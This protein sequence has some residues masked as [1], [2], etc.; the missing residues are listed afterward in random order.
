MKNTAL[1]NV[2]LIAIDDAN[3]GI[4]ISDARLPD[5]PLIFVN[6]GFC[7]MTGYNADEVMGKNCRFL[8]GKEINQESVRRVKKSI[9]NKDSI[10]EEIINFKK[11]GT[12]FW[13]RLSITPIFDDSGILSHFI[14]VQEDITAKKEKE[15]LQ[16]KMDDQILVNK[17]TLIAEEKQKKEIGVEL[18]DNVN[19]ILAALKLYLAMALRDEFVRTEMLEKS[20]EMLNMAMDEI[21]KLSKSLVGP[22]I[23]QETLEQAV[24]ELINYTQIGVSFIIKLV[25]DEDIEQNLSQSMKLTLYRIIQEQLNNIG[26]YANPHIVKIEFTK[27]DDMIHLSVKDDGIGFNNN[28]TRH[29][30]GLKNMKHR[31]EMENGH[32]TILTS[33]GSGCEIKVDL[34]YE[35]IR[36]PF[37]LEEMYI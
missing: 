3:E 6:K 18:H 37:V 36:S 22:N 16:H 30:I 26:K 17:T 19:Q 12:I 34:P 29:G 8:Q 20:E 31:S 33:L 10:I 14:G 4:T 23:K 35:R 9:Q 24:S 13:N 5:N 27:S 21:R 28:S 1:Q 7:S 2:M 25:F 15:S 11:D 32:F